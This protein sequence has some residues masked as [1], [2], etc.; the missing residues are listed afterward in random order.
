[1]NAVVAFGETPLTA[2]SRDELIRALQKALGHPL[3]SDASVQS[4]RGAPQ[5][6]GKN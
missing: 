2:E 5:L 4:R 1:M 3:F 6:S